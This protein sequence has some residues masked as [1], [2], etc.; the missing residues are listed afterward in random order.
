MKIKTEAEYKAI[1]KRIEELMPLVDDNTPID[2]INFIELDLL[3]GIAEEWEDENVTIGEPGL[4]EMLKLRMYERGLSQRKLAELINVS[5]ARITE[6]LS[7]KLPPTKVAREICV[8][9]NIE[10]SIVLGL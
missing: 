5:P 2:D 1:M 8:Q 9:L 10:P 6:Y 7:G 3:S 4:P